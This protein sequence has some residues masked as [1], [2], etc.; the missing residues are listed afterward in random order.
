LQ[1]TRK[2][3]AAKIKGL[4]I[5]PDGEVWASVSED[6][7]LKLWSKDGEVLQ[8][9]PI[10]TEFADIVRFQPKASVV[11][12][13][14]GKDKDR[15]VSLW[16][17]RQNTLIPLQSSGGFYVRDMQFSPDGELLATG[18]WNGN[19]TFWDLAGKKQ[20]FFFAGYDGPI[21]AIKFHP[22]GQL[23]AVT[24]GPSILLFDRQGVLV[25]SFQKTEHHNPFS[26]EF[27]PDSDTLVTGHR[28]GRLVL[29]NL[30]LVAKIPKEQLPLH[31]LTVQTL[32]GANRPRQA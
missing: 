17:W 26:L 13:A 12:V 25:Q 1:S 10:E 8:T 28:F 31:S 6:G 20:Y 3:H 18:S 15:S 7:T 16:N 21:S 2:A 23:I 4:S 30:D 22:N 11:A 5:S 14:S 32:Q 24:S 9:L 29:W 27:S 19:L